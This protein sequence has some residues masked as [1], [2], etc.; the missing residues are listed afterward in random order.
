MLINKREST[1]L[2]YLNDPKAFIENSNDMDDIYDIYE[3]I[4][5]CNPNKKWKILIV[6]GN[7]IVDLLSNKNL[8]PI[9][10]EYL[11]YFY[12]TILFC[13]F[14]KQYTKFNTIFWYENSKQKRTLTNCI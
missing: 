6:F 1:G 5:E 14:K 9:V 7:M 13:C 2:K 12:C 8:N 11:S 4:E 3:N 10:T